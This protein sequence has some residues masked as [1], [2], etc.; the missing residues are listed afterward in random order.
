MN[1]SIIRTENLQKKY[2]INSN[3][4]SAVNGIDLDIRQGDFVS[5]MGPS[6]CGK[7]SLM[8]ILGL[9]DSATAGNYF[10][11][12][13]EVTA[14]KES[15]RSLLRKGNIGFIFQNF[16]LIDDLSV[17]E[18][19]ELPLLYLKTPAEQRKKKVNT[20]LEHLEIPELAKRFPYQLS[21]GEQ[22]R[23]AL[24]RAVVFEPKLLLADEPTGNLDMNNSH[25]IMQLLSKINSDGK[26]VIL[27][28][29]EMECANYSRTKI[30]IRD[31]KIIP[32]QSE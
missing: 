3:G 27:V 4:T 23:V 12:D 14:L 29:H 26:T 19:I 18:N 10:F 16:N 24:S 25:K 15:A 13:Q 1:Q 17:F 11:L 30:N 2:F 22:Q 8:N 28:T 9:L 21:G 6:G 7:S 5:I 31:G 20:I 32:N